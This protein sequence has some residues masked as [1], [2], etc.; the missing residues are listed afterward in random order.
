MSVSFRD[1]FSSVA[2]RKRDI[3]FNVLLVMPKLKFQKHPLG[4]ADKGFI[5]IFS[6][7]GYSQDKNV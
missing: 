5:F 6:D 2:L 4:S 1:G 3:A 7:V